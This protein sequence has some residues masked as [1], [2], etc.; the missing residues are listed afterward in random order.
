[1]VST[2]I[3]VPEDSQNIR[4]ICIPSLSPR[5]IIMDFYQFNKHGIN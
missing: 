4:L 3:S 5:Y 2:C 1:M